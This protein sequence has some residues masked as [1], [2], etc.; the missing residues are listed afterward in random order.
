M[1][2]ST[3]K[4]GRSGRFGDSNSSTDVEND[5]DNDQS[6]LGDEDI[7]WIEGNLELA[8][9]S[10]ENI[11]QQ[12]ASRLLNNQGSSPISIHENDQVIRI[13]SSSAID[14]DGILDNNIEDQEMDSGL[15]SADVNK[16][17]EHTKA[18][19]L[20][21]TSQFLDRNLFKFQGCSEDDHQEKALRLHFKEIFTTGKWTGIDD[22]PDMTLE[23]W[24]LL[25]R[26]IGISCQNI[27]SP[28]EL[29][30]PRSQ[31]HQL[32]QR[33]CTPHLWEN[34]F[35]ISTT[36]HIDSI[37]AMPTSLQVANHGIEFNMSPQY[38]HNIRNDLHIKIHIN[39][40]PG[41]KPVTVTLD[42]VPHFRLGIIP[43]LVHLE[44]FVFLPGLYDECR[45]SNFPTQEQ[46]TRFFDHLLLPALASQ[47]DSH[48]AQYLPSSYAH[49][50]KNAQAASAEGFK[51]RKMLKEINFIHHLPSEYLGNV[52]NYIMDHV[53]DPGFHEFGNIILFLNGK[54]LDSRFKKATPLDSFSNFL[55]CLKYT[56]DLQ[57]LEKET[58]WIDFGRE[59]VHPAMGIPEQPIKEHSDHADK[60][61]TLLC[62]I[63]V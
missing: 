23:V 60:T 41:R 46:L 26:G 30:L 57:Y 50:K 18:E 63:V 19:A 43:G 45:P 40:I 13:T 24:R 5:M 7:V 20:I 51:C 4:S 36:F 1:D 56:L 27:G 3:A 10:E 33:D 35:M 28:P 42:M 52:W 22:L 9:D 62:K 11:L 58:T 48:Y 37:M 38:I 16:P 2:S 54:N 44:L 34:Q 39:Q 25:G 6:K 47:T 29:S 59:V 55:H 21:V 14:I 17:E 32:L 31:A 61:H 53:R 49:A 15:D 8:E 12:T